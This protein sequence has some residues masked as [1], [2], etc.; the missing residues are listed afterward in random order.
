MKKILFI[1]LFLLIT[2]YSITNYSFAQTPTSTP[3]PTFQPTCTPSVPAT[4]TPAIPVS[5]ITGVT[6]LTIMAGL[7]LA[8]LGF[9]L[10]LFSFEGRRSDD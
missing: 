8:F 2:N 5:G 3:H 9:S 6:S 7:V 4:A 1:L 10:F